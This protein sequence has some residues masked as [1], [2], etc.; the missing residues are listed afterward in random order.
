MI[1]G[2]IFQCRN[3]VLVP[4]RGR[5]ESYWGSLSE[6]Q[7]TH[8]V[9]QP[10]DRLGRGSWNCM[11]K[12][13]LHSSLSR[14]AVLFGSTRGKF[15]LSCVQVE[16]KRLKP[17]I[18]SANHPQPIRA[19]SRDKRHVRYPDDF[20]LVGQFSVTPMARLLEYRAMGFPRG[21]RTRFVTSP[22]WLIGILIFIVL[23]IT[24]GAV[25]IILSNKSIVPDIVV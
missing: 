17:A 10:V 15:Y 12:W 3:I 22:R 16:D 23:E 21:T 5:T 6:P 25:S 9:S 13:D 4:E 7:W 8:L 20:S 19:A 18:V 2:E 14:N 24:V 11:V 1:Q